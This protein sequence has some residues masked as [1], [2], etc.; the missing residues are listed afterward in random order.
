MVT[1]ID[2]CLI[3]GFYPPQLAALAR[4][5]DLNQE[6]GRYAAAVKALEK[7][8]RLDG[9]D[10]VV[11]NRLGVGYISAGVRECGFSAHDYSK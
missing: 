7:L 5:A 3:R 1:M 10:T 6:R 4:M 11:A 8:Y 9:N 2:I